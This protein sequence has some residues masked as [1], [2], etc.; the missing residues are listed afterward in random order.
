MDEQDAL[1]TV[2]ERHLADVVRRTRRPTHVDPLLRIGE[3]VQLN[4]SFAIEASD[5]AG[6][7]PGGL[8]LAAAEL[9]RV[10]R[11]G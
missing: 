9:P 2:L 1:V 11:H 7:K 5:R 6:A 8:G 4:H 10:R 3:T